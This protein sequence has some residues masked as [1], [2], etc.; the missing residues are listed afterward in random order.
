MSP[1]LAKLLA[2]RLGDYKNRLF[3][4]HR[5]NF[6]PEDITLGKDDL[7]HTSQSPIP[8]FSSEGYSSVYEPRERIE[9]LPRWEDMGDWGW[10]KLLWAKPDLNPGLDQELVER[11]FSNLGFHSYSPDELPTVMSEFYGRAMDPVDSSSSVRSWRG[12]LDADRTINA[13]RELTDHAL[14]PSQSDIPYHY[15]P[16]DREKDLWALRHYFKTASEARREMFS[17]MSRKGIPAFRYDNEYETPYWGDSVGVLDPDFLISRDR[18]DLTPDSTGLDREIKTLM[19]LYPPD[20]VPPKQG[21]LPAKW[22][23]LIEGL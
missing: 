14:R 21:E 6:M 15:T 22:K 5:E 8:Y 4:G 11:S 9:R 23:K 18:M 13:Y 1:V 19:E 2:R 3:H 10:D 12:E 16:E 20:Y 17:E 7:I